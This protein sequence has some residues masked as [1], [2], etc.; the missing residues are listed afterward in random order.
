MA[1]WTEPLPLWGVCGHEGQS[2]VMAA[3][4]YR[5]PEEYYRGRNVSRYAVVRDYHSIC[6]ARLE[7]ACALLKE[8]YPGGEFAWHC[9]HSPL[10]EVELAVR[11]GLGVRGRHN[12]LITE[13]YGSWVF[14]GGIVSSVPLTAPA[15][16]PLP[17]PCKSCPGHCVKACPTGALDD[18]FDRKRCL[19]FLTQRKGEL[20]ELCLLHAS[21]CWGCD[22]CQEVCPCNR[23]SKVDPL[24]EFLIDPLPR[25]TAETSLEGWAYAWRGAEVFRRNLILSPE[26]NGGCAA[27]DCPTAGG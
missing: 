24:P 5:L 26:A 1:D 23:R 7:Q 4:P 15:H 10:H 27:G 22:L 18:V 3:F 19:S 9:D 17:S 14:L 13:A 21:S 6:G 20:P 25:V 8:Q 11:A 2:V 16:S 12:L